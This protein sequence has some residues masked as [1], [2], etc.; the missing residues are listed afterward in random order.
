M[1]PH[2]GQLFVCPARAMRDLSDNCLTSSF[3]VDVF[4]CHLLLPLAAMLVPGR[5]LLCVE[6][7]QFVRIL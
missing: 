1:I 5:E 7:H 2:I 4:N 3:D 6:R